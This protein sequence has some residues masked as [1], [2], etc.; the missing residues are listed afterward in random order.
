MRRT[1]RLLAA[2]TAMALPAAAQAQACNAAQNA[3]NPLVAMGFRAF[4]RINNTAFDLSCY[5]SNIGGGQISLTAGGAPT[6]SVGSGTSAITASVN[7]GIFDLSIPNQPEFNYGVASNIGTGATTPADF[8]FAFSSPLSLGYYYSA[9]D[10]Q[11]GVT[12]ASGNPNVSIV[13][14]GAPSTV[15]LGGGVP[16]YLVAQTNY[17]SVTGANPG[18]VNV[19]NVGNTACTSGTACNYAPA[20]ASIS[21][22]QF[23]NWTTVIS[24]REAR[25]ST[26]RAANAQVNGQVDLIGTA[27]PEPATMT[28]M[29][30]GLLALAG[31]G[32]KRRRN[33]V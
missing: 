3:A 18:A 19:V 15:A 22:S 33:T 20:S 14:A 10:A 25:P 27:V 23:Y 16:N 11:V 29:G 31:V 5:Y 32:I 21:P 6:V 24:Y 26:S 17:L 2:A 30:T 8:V 28:L 13:P 12:R 1:L 7:Q 9:A 4:V